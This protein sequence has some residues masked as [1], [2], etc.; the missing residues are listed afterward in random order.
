MAALAATSRATGLVLSPDDDAAV[1][2][3]AVVRFHLRAF[4][5]VEKEARAGEV[6]AVHQLRVATRR[7]RAALHLFGSCLPKRFVEATQRE[8]AWL[9]AAIG[10]VRDLDVLGQAVQLRAA[11]LDPELR[12]ALG[13]LGIAIHDRRAAALDTLSATLRS[14][15]CH[16]LLE[17]LG[18]FADPPKAPRRNEPLGRVA[19]AFATPLLRAVKR[20]GR[21]IGGGSPP[22]ELHRL[23]VRVKRLRYALE[24]L[25]GFGMR[26]IRDLIARLERLQTVLGDAQDAAT[27]LAWLRDYA[28]ADGVPVPSL[29][30]IG[31][32]LQTLS[33][34]ASKRRRRALRTWRKVDRG[35]LLET[36]EA[37]LA[38]HARE[39]RVDRVREAGWR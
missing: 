22:P 21:R 11:R 34:R 5:A 35:R 36:V 33:R 19:P 37:D 6:E 31:A 20:A 26:S 3:R 15:R 13:P 38:R 1:A 9:A 29:L 30:A 23:R 8:L 25:R 7:I 10:A 14:S 24:T 2:A 17:R 39:Q 18:T 28:A 27:Q 4:A 32:L 12:G 16:R